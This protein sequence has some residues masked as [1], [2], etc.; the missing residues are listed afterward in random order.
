MK[1][2]AGRCFGSILAWM[3]ENIII[4]SLRQGLVCATP[5]IM[6][7]CIGT[8]LTSM[9]FVHYQNFIN[10]FLIGKMIFEVGQWLNF[11]MLGSVSL[12]LI[13]TIS[14]SYAKK[15]DIDNRYLYPICSV[16][17][18]IFFTAP[19]GR[20]I[21][22][23]IFNTT[24]MFMA[25]LV[26]ILTC[27][28]LRGSIQ[29][30]GSFINKYYKEGTDLSFQSI[31]SFLVPVSFT[32]FCFIII[33]LLLLMVLGTTDIQNIGSQIAEWGFEKIG[34]NFWGALLFVF[35]IHISWFFGIHGSNL[36]F[37][38]ATYLFE[39]GMAVNMALD[40]MGKQPTEIY[41]KTFIDTFILCGG[42]G[43]TLC[44]L[45]ALLLEASEN[46]KSNNRH[47]F[48]LSIF[49][50]IFNINEPLLFGLPLVF[51]PIMVIPFVLVPI[52]F[53]ITSS[54]SMHLGIVPM[55]IHTVQW[56]TPILVNGYLATESINASILQ[57]V[58]LL[59]GTLVYLPF[60]RYAERYRTKVLKDNI[61]KLQKRVV[62]AEDI[63]KSVHLL[64]HTIKEE[65]VARMLI[66]DLRYAMKHNK[67]TLYYQP[68][69]C[70]DGT[71]LGAEALLRWDHPAVG[72]IYPPLIIE[73]AREDNL[74]DELGLQII[75]LA[76][77]DSERLSN[78]RDN[79]IKISVNISTNQLD[80]AEF[81]ANVKAILKKYYLGN[82]KLYFEVT[83]Q[84]A[85]SSTEIIRSRIEELRT[86]GIDF[87]MDDFGMGH[88]SMMYLQNNEFASVK[89]DGSLVRNM[90][91]NKKSLNIIDGI[92]NLAEHLG[93]SVIAEYVETEEQ[94]LTLEKI[95]C[96]IYQG[97]L[98]GKAVKLEE[99]E[100]MLVRAGKNEEKK[101]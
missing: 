74:E 49:S 87:I 79:P 39:R 30:S 7:G 23:D 77:R 90:L 83:E 44:L 22:F 40:A 80:N 32:T 62:Q 21:T 60:I 57:L 64:E 95:G 34:C 37:G 38:V 52:L 6:L 2:K 72:F 68:Q 85:L 43:A 63:G 53:L 35:L 36:L 19:K 70:A 88:S 86:Y 61:K 31:V 65:N 27:Q 58:N 69:V 26:T 8:V 13:I 78:S 91:N 16:C 71:I 92:Q 18:Y 66:S 20:A 99:F 45:A 29:I 75:E 93:C 17:T 9:P 55:P 47:I 76:C 67:I 54:L 5:F 97:Y 42:S 24:W 100:D 4:F 25:M 10:N 11:S 82:A 41:T 94:R 98:F 48:K 3:E 89:L 33:K 28:I 96:R 73:L 84:I 15:M 51:N 56:T 12:I 1:S 59:L 14:Y 46:K 101:C 81:C 50:S